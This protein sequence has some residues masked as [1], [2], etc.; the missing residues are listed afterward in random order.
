MDN[1]QTG[2]MTP[3]RNSKL[4]WTIIIA[5]AVIVV[6]LL[7][8]FLVKPNS[9]KV[10]GASTANSSGYQAVFLTNGQ[11]YFGKLSNENSDWITLTNIYYLQVTQDLQNAAGADAAK[12]AN[13]S[14]TGGASS[15]NSNIQLVK[16]GSE[17]HGPTDEMHIEHD[18]VLFWEDMQDGSK[19]MQAINQYQ[20]K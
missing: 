3:R 7:V 8:W 11:V 13:P 12:N 16:L 19:V 14:S 6:V 10:S 17:L 2:A 5:A 9:G 20:S 15:A 18:K 4:L 1:M